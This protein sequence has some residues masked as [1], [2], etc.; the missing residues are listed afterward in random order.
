[1][2][3]KTVLVTFNK[4]KDKTRKYTG[5]LLGAINSDEFAHIV[6]DEPTQRKIKDRETKPLKEISK[7]FI[8][9][10]GLRLVFSLKK[11][12]GANVY[13]QLFITERLGWVTE[14]RNKDLSDSKLEFLS[15]NDMEENSYY[16]ITERE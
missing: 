10:K 11:K 5:R 14:V 6:K 13:N 16:T 7:E 3:K 1:M 2:A 4:E 9:F 15:V 12:Q 8:D